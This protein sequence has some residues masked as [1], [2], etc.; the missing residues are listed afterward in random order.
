ML[1]PANE[2]RGML[3]SVNPTD[4]NEVLDVR[5]LFLAH[6]MVDGE[7]IQ[8]FTDNSRRIVD[9]SP[10][11]ELNIVS[12]DGREPSFSQWECVPPRTEAGE[13]SE[14][15]PYPDRRITL[16]LRDDGQWVVAIVV[17]EA[18]PERG[19]GQQTIDISSGKGGVSSLALDWK[20]Q[21]ID[22]GDLENVLATR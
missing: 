12:S 7:N 9:I 18:D 5:D 4:T 19:V 6:V 10:H 17:Q 3:M 21:E 1:N 22:Y 8:A 13:A 11:V 2:F 15:N 16:R 14:D 20:N